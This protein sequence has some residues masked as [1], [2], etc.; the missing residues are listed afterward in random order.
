MKKK[1]GFKVALALGGGGARGLAHIGVLE[2][3]E[4]HSIPIDLVVGTSMGA[5]VGSIFCLNP[6]ANKLK[7]QVLEW[8]NHPE[9]KKMESLFTRISEEK[10]KKFIFKKL[11][12][13][14]KNLYFWNLQSA[15]RW[16]IR[17]EPIVKLLKE[18]V[19]NKGFSDTQIPFACVAAD[20]NNACV[21]IIQRGKLLEAILAS[22]SLPGVFAPLKRGNQLLIDG[23]ILSLVPARQAR[24]LGADFVIGID[25][26]PK[27]SNK[28]LLTGLDIM[29][30][31]DQIKSFHLNQINLKYC[32]WVIR[33]KT[34]DIGWSEFSKLFLCIQEGERQ[35]SENIADI[36][37]AL[38]KK[39]RFY[40]FKK[41]I[42][43][44]KGE[45]YVD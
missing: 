6:D 13:R 37:A 10:E 41:L 7:Q 9:I 38:D 33:P 22:S 23:G 21:V 28:R 12:S 2:V 31:A 27:V 15:K 16:L 18:L 20:L 36:K 17:S 35:T 14:I 1:R 26:S 4:S 34:F 11:L 29:Y 43:Q 19:D 44:F 32:D 30:Q 24:F 5:I 42:S 45:R 39:R 40:P 3:L 25:I 8:I